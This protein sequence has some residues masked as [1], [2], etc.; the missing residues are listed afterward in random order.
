MRTPHAHDPQRASTRA[1]AAKTLFTECHH[2]RT[3]FVRYSYFCTLEFLVDTNVLANKP[4][5]SCNDTASVLPAVASTAAA[6]T[7]SAEENSLPSRFPWM[8]EH[9]DSF[10][11][12][13]PVRHV[14]H[15]KGR[16]RAGT[17]I[18]PETLAILTK[19][20]D[21]S[22]FP[23]TSPLVSPPSFDAR[24]C[25]PPSLSSLTPDCADS[26]P[27]AG[28]LRRNGR[29]YLLHGHMLYG[30]VQQQWK[31]SLWQVLSCNGLQTDNC[32]NPVNQSFNVY[33]RRRNRA[34]RE[35]PEHWR[36]AAVWILQ[37]SAQLQSLQ[38]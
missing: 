29:T 34:L 13:P 10:P 20:L 17:I 16:W 15:I 4:M 26:D 38:L 12:V 23:P 5:T 30:W 6:A 37:R 7:S 8:H 14:R 32:G 28:I 19:H 25:C 1:P 18:D 24:Q 3:R 27:R 31:S 33:V 11:P 35:H 22:L 2:P 21:G 9:P 36:P